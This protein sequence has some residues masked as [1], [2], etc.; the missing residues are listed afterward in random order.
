MV[1]KIRSSPGVAFKISHKNCMGPRY[2]KRCKRGDV[3]PPM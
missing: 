2:T 3:L 1:G